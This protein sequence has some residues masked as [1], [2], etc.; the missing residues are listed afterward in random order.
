MA[1]DFS[2]TSNETVR[3]V[4]KAVRGIKNWEN[5][6]IESFIGLKENRISNVLKGRSRLSN[7]EKERLAALIEEK[8]EPY[9][10]RFFGHTTCAPPE[11][12]ARL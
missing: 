11:S 5:A 12:L 6:R 4:V 3:S 7:E 10:I 8:L 2:S 1:I 9:E